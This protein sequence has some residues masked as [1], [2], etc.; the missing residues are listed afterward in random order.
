MQTAFAFAGVPAFDS[1]IWAAI[2]RLFHFRYGELGP[3]Q[4]DERGT[5]A[6]GRLH[7]AGHRQSFP[8]LLIA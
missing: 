3:R 8:A 1:V 5:S 6:L 7:P 4:R 2:A